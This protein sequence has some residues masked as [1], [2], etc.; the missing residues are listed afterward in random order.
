MRPINYKRQYDNVIKELK[1]K[2][3]LKKFNAIDISH[4]NYEDYQDEI[5]YMAYT[6]YNEVDNSYMPYDIETLKKYII[7]HHKHIQ[8]I[9]K[10]KKY[11]WCE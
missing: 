3:G 9:K 4:F 2:V 5:L 1:Y 11:C 8:S 6:Y 10:S 7:Y